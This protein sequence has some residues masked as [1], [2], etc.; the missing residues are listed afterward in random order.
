[1]TSQQV[2][3]D[4]VLRKRAHGAQSV[5]KD[6]FDRSIRHADVHHLGAG[7]RVL[8]IHHQVGIRNAV[9]PQLPAHE[10]SPMIR[11]HF[12]DDRDGITTVDF[13]QIQTDVQRHAAGAVNKFFPGQF[14][15][16]DE[17]AGIDIR[18]LTRCNRRR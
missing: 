5:T 4:I 13:S 14:V 1:M 10:L 16:I 2:E 8:R 17:S 18:K 15:R 9:L 3:I 12:A 6:A 7:G 11:A